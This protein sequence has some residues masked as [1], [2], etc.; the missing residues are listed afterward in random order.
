MGDNRSLLERAAGLQKRSALLAVPFVAAAALAPGATA[1]P[2]FPV[3][4]LAGEPGNAGAA[5]HRFVLRVCNRTPR[6]IWISLASRRTEAADVWFVSGWWKIGA[7]GCEELGRFAKPTIYLHAENAEGRQWNGV[8]AKLCV[9]MNN[10][11]YAYRPAHACEGVLR[12]FYKKTID[13]SWSSFEWL[14]AE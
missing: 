14:V 5:V 11:R 1:D 10:F 12:G 4:A 13:G 7:H 6:M 9:Q 3:I 2:R 8:D